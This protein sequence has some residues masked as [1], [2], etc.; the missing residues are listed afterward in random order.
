[1]VLGSAERSEDLRAYYA[2]HT[3][4][5]R[6][7]AVLLARLPLLHIQGP[8]HE[9]GLGPGGPSRRT[10]KAW[11]V[12]F[13]SSWGCSDSS[14]WP[15]RKA[16]VFCTRACQLS[17]YSLGDFLETAR[18]V[19]LGCAPVKTARAARAAHLPTAPALDQRHRR[20]R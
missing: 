5:D 12:S 16:D 7:D 2:K 1:V 17:A 20:S 10:T 15:P 14:L 18:P 9:H 4:S 8:H 13:A 19:R 11:P 3:K 6:L